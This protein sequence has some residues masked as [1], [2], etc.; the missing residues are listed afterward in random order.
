MLGKN[1]ETHRDVVNWAEQEVSVRVAVD[2]GLPL[3]HHRL[4]IQ[5]FDDLRL[6]LTRKID[7]NM[8]FPTNPNSFIF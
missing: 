3:K 6:L 1:E 8:S 4:I 2:L 7:R 5:R